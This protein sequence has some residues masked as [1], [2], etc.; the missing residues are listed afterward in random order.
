MNSKWKIK[1]LDGFV[2]GED[3]NLYR[4]PF[5]SKGKTYGLRKI[6]KQYPN[7]YK[8]GNEWIS[9]RQMKN[10]IYLDEEPII[11]FNTSDTPF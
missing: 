5:E 8:V 1:G 7:R 4:L 9:E 2:F 10:R 6:K 3:K 11:L